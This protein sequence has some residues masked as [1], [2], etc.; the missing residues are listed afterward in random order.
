MSLRWDLLQ[1]YTPTHRRCPPLRTLFGLA[2]LLLR[3]GC[4]LPP[5]LVLLLTLVVVLPVLL[6]LLL[7][8]VL[9]KVMV[10]VL[11]KVLVMVLVML[12]ME[13]PVV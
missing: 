8:K 2:L 1:V 6:L 10:T 4:M 5:P 11:V 3:V 13:N 12:Y 9:V 7:V